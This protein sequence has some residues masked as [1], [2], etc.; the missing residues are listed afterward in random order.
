MREMLLWAYVWQA[1]ARFQALD[2]VVTAVGG[3]EAGEGVISAAI[4]VLIMAFLGVGM[5]LAF[6]ATLGSTTKNVDSQ[7]NQIGR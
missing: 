1:T 6:K 4:A 7:V 5:W 3:E 2:R